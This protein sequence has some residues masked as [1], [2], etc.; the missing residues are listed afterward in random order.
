VQHWVWPT[1]V[2]QLPPVR[3]TVQWLVTHCSPSQ[4]SL[5]SMQ[6]SFSALQ[7]QVP[8]EQVPQQQS[9]AVL[10]L[11]VATCAGGAAQAQKPFEQSLEQQSAL[12]VHAVPRARQAQVPVHCPVQQVA[13]VEQPA[14][15]ALQLTQ[16]PLSQRL[17]Q[18][19]PSTM[20]LPVAR[21]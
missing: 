2:V 14:P 21:H 18:Q 4:H 3:Q 7:K 20:Q 10:H 8:P 17:L 1:L 13:P 16:L 5:D 6:E 9:A 12:R 15:M 19:S 11:S